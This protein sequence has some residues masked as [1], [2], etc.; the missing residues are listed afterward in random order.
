M[1]DFFKLK[2]NKT[3]FF[4]ELL[5]GVTTFFTMAYIIFVNP[6]ILSLNAGMGWQA[7]FVATVLACVAGTLIMALYANVP[8]ALAPGM[9][10]NAF[11]TYTL[12][13]QFGLAWQEALGIVVICG[14]VVVI[15]TVTKF[16]KV[17]V[18]AIPPFLKDSITCAIG[19][20]IAYLGFKNASFFT[21]LFDSGSYSVL[22]NGSAISNSSAMPALA[23]FNDPGVILGL[24]GIIIM[25]ILAARQIKGGLFIGIVVI[26][27]LGIPL[28]VVDISKIK[29]LDF[30]AIASVKD[31]A[32]AAFGNQGFESLFSDFNKIILTITASLALF[33]SIT[34]D[35]IGT[36][37]G[38]GRVSG[39]FDEKDAKNMSQKGVKSKFEK[40]LFA[41]GIAS[42]V[43]GFLGT[44]S[45]TTYVESTAGISVGGRTGLTGVVVAV[46]F[47][48]CLPFAG[49][50]S[51]VPAQ[52]TAP[53]LIIVGVMM[54][55]SITKIKWTNFQEAVPAFFTISI[56]AFAFNI[57]YGIAAG[58][59]LY[60]IIKLVTGKVKEIHPVL[61][62]VAVL[63][64]I[65]FAIIALRG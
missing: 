54:M 35:A 55:S 57:S 21:F 25:I 11:F 31:V 61:A 1:K 43:G 58:F 46:L 63:F 3:N 45:V 37:I 23:V 13:K 29:L 56:M 7:V 49:I 19:F 51:I 62:A 20:F 59:I 48:L 22:E 2:D 6:A 53:V 50:V 42:C 8:F 34:F 14:V 16:R 41:D 33:L 28:G 18:A 40:A 30:H 65:N 47:L 12:C 32:F 4:T 39:I 44:S 5:A 24:L 64:L 52:A 15:V 17:I 26:T 9:G 27:V 38:A 36:F 60:C 10:L